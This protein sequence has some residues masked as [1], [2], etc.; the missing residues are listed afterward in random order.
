M[1]TVRQP[2]AARPDKQARRETAKPL[3]LLDFP[4]LAR[5]P[6][7]R[8]LGGLRAMRANHPVHTQIV[9]T[10]AAQNAITNLSV[11]DRC[12]DR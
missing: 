12:S 3:V 5:R 4:A 8:R 1:R 7:T 11:I 6:G 9:R 10:Q 2:A